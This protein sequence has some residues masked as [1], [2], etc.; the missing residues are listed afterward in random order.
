M[1]YM[2]ITFF[3]GSIYGG[4]AERVTCNLASYLVRKGYQ[5][6]ILT[7]SETER[8]YELDERVTVNT[9]LPLSERKGKLWNI[10][11]RLPRFL[12]YLKNNKTDIYIVMLPK[13]ILM[14]LAFRK[15]IRAKVI[16][17]ERNDPKAYSKI[18]A[19]FLTKYASRAEGWVFQT[20]DA[21]KWYEN[22]IN[23]CKST[24]IPNAINP[25][26]IRTH[27]E[28][29]KSKVIA[30]VGRLSPQKNFGV[31]I[32]AFA[33]I[34]QEF[35]EYNLVIYGQGNQE[36]EL[37]SLVTYLKLSKRIYFPGNILNIADEIEKSTMFVLSSDFEGMPN[38]LMEAM[39]LGLPCVATD[40]PCGGPRCLIQNG[41]NGILVPVGDVDK[42]ANA[43]RSV[44]FDLKKAESMGQNARKIAVDLAPEKIY[45]M[46][47]K[48]ICDVINQES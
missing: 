46:W 1:N 4:G 32:K 35:P 2:K 34:A 11:V 5:T 17:A 27:Y 30:G 42:M 14:M 13:T 44:L 41:V 40:C 15:K 23:N 3:I 22:A 36:N 6:E 12:K 31:L 37:K 25:A 43:M 26:F 48:F 21:Q 24:I 33:K 10:A 45:G 39:A 29:D 9:L 38:A 16:T 20:Y 19:Y 47:E 28:G 7:I 8:I 18:L